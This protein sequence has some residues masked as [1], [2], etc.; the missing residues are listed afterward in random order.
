MKNLIYVTVISF[1]L[2]AIFSASAF[3]QDGTKTEFN[4]LKTEVNIAVA[5]IFA[6]NNFLYLVYADGNYFPYTYADY[7]YQPELVVGVKFHGAKGA[8]RL[9]TNLKYSSNTNENDGGQMEKYTFKTFGTML[10]LGYE[11]HS[12]F[13]RVNI[14]YG[15]DV[16]TSYASY[17]TK[18]EYATNY[19]PG[20]ISS[21]ETKTHESA[22]GINPLIGVNFFITPHLSIGTEVKFTAEYASG[23][24][25]YTSSSS[26]SSQDSKS[27]GFRTRFGPL[28]FLSIN[29]HF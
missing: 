15:F 5:N 19:P 26:S 7:Y 1:M 14:Y 9:G 3:S 21:N 13:N 6:E 12:T 20:H 18:Q 25:E 29:L 24:S 11:W 23:K 22:Y 17:Y 8:F 2:S 10:Y 27:S 28:G 4:T 16:S